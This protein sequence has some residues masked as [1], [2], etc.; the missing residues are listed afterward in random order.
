MMSETFENLSTEA[1]NELHTFRD[2][3]RWGMTQFE[4]VGSHYGHGTSDAWDEAV[5]LIAH[6]LHLSPEVNHEVLDAR[7]TTAEKIEI[8]Q[9]M[10]KR[11]EQRIPVPYLIH[12]AHFANLDFYVDERVLIPRSPIAELIENEFSPWLKYIECP[13]ILDLCTGSGCI[14]IA[15][16][17]T[18][19]NAIIDATDIS[20]D[21]LAVA[22]MNLARHRTIADRVNL[23][24]SDIW[25]DIPDQK[26]DLIISNPPYVSAEEM[27]SLPME[28]S[29][30]P[31]LALFAEQSGLSVVIEILKKAGNYLKNT[32][33]LVV[34]V[35][36]SQSELIEK[37][38]QVPFLWLEF[39]RGGEGVFLL[40]ADQLR[41]YAA[42]F[43]VENGF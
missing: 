24:T 18:F 14:A 10:K 36:S 31:S 39:A 13:R 19:A 11:V 43:E 34:E 20:S 41:T 25:Q 35:G 42:V 3:V 32:G 15:C 23:I 21:A 37:F 6:S 2:F 33:I 12:K 7:L 4:K 22:E 16:A 30:E 40:T 28:Y 17:Y 27:R 1:L 5:A 9:L 29:H 38:P 26:Y 8:I